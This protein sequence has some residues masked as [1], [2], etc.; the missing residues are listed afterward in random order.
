MFFGDTPM[1]KDNHGGGRVDILLYAIVRLKLASESQGW[2]V[3]R[4]RC[5]L[6]LHLWFLIPKRV[7]TIDLSP[8]LNIFLYILTHFLNRLLMIFWIK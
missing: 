1:A 5:R 8:S 7:Q 2:W 6:Y 4:F 3:V